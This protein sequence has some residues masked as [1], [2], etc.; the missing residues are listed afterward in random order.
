MRKKRNAT[1]S[2]SSGR[3]EVRFLQQEGRR[4]LGAYAQ[5]NKP[6]AAKIGTEEG[7]DSG[8]GLEET[9]HIRTQRQQTSPSKKI[10]RQEE[11]PDKPKGAVR[12]A[13]RK[14]AHFLLGLHQDTGTPPLDGK[15]QKGPDGVTTLPKARAGPRSRFPNA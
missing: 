9:S 11:G 3:T 2:M 8:K 15:A 6:N 4:D 1:P 13:W 12:R 14:R 7:L 5:T 10:W